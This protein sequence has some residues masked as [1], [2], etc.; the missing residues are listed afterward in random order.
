MEGMR[1]Q[2]ASSPRGVDDWL[3]GNDACRHWERK[4]EKSQEQTGNI[5]LFGIWAI[6]Q[7][8]QGL[9]PT[10]G[11]QQKEHDRAQE[12]DG[13]DYQ[14]RPGGCEEGVSWGGNEV[15]HVMVPSPSASRDR[16]QDKV[17][18]EQVEPQAEK[19]H[20]G[21]IFIE[22]TPVDNFHDHEWKDQEKANERCRPEGL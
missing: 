13:A 22:I 12:K 9:S 1:K 18:G 16:Q 10:Q 11:F 8:V 4:D 21:E 3:T 17:D 7:T 6:E 15:R 2:A 14:S 19:Q 5:E 20:E